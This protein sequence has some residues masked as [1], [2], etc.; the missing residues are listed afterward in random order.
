MQ[1]IK[2]RCR[3]SRRVAGADSDFDFEC[4]HEMLGQ[5]NALISQEISGSVR[6]WFDGRP[7][8][9]RTLLPT[10]SILTLADI[11]D[12]EDIERILSF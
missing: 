3:D 1:K 9:A 10:S 6:E 12:Q 5:S 11:K 4:T 8:S 2:P 7:H